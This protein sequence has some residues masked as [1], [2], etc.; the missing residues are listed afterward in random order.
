MH[1]L[2]PSQTILF[3]QA[4]LL[5]DGA[6]NPGLEVA[7]NLVCL[8]ENEPVVRVVLLRCDAV[9]LEWLGAESSVSSLREAHVVVLRAAEEEG[10]GREGEPCVFLLGQR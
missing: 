5:Q 9:L 4:G 10:R 8:R 3:L 7:R 6:I 2:L 1:R